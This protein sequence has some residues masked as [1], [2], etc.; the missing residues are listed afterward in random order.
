MK[1][2]KINQLYNR[3]RLEWHAAADQEEFV[4]SHAAE[5]AP[6][7]EAFPNALPDDPTMEFEVT[8]W[9]A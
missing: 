6:L 9:I 1:K 2:A 4:T 3:P 5:S 8:N 7:E